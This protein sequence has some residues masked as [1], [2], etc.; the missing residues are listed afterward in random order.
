M[1]KR[2]D[3]KARRAIRK[4]GA[5]GTLAGEDTGRRPRVLFIEDNPADAEIVTRILGSARIGAVE[6]AETAEEGVRRF[7]DEKWGLLLVDYRLPGSS[8]LE[9]LERIREMDPNVPAIMLTGMGNEQ[10]AAAAIKLGADEYVSKDAL[11]TTLPTTARLL[12]ERTSVDQQ[13]FRLLKKNQ[14]DEELGEVIE[15]QDRLVRSLPADSAPF[16][17][18]GMPVA[19]RELVSAFARIYRVVVTYGGLPT[20]AVADLCRL[21]GSQRLSSRQIVEIHAEAADQVIST[22]ETAQ[23]DLASRLNEGLILALLW[24]NDS[25]RR[26]N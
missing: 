24:L 19:R 16:H 3:R 11:T 22:T 10:V 8:G 7:R 17:E 25:W 14:R 26:A 21:I 5:A 18:E 15:S 23:N 6:V 12:L 2:A 13:M 9:A 20:T 1:A 4:K